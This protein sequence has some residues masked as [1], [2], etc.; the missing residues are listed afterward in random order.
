MAS[1]GISKIL[2]IRSTRVAPAIYFYKGAQLGMINYIF[3]DMDN[4]IAE[5]VTCEDVPYS[6]GLYLNKRPIQIVID[7]IVSMY[8]DC[9]LIVL[10][11]TAGGRRGALEKRAWLDIYFPYANEVYLISQEENKSDF[12]AKYAKKNN[13]DLESCMLI[14]DKKDILQDCSVLGI[15]VK[16]PQQV[17]CD[18]EE[19]LNLD[20]RIS[21]CQ[22]KKL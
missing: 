1:I 22:R 3:V 8:K 13:L 14:D 20:I 4:T 15:N 6:S 9:R 16:Y 21:K 5:N 12:I 18:Y 17:I 11:K 2:D 19:L 10:S 7:G